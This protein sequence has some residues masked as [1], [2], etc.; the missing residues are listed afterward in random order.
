[1]RA[2]RRGDAAGAGE[3]SSMKCPITSIHAKAPFGAA[4]AAYF[5]YD[6]SMR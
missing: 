1:M 6:V 3:G 5:G 2:Q 4:F